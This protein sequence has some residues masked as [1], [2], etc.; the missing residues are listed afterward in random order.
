MEVRT[1]KPVLKPLPREKERA[2][3]PPSSPPL[4]QKAVTN[5]QAHTW[6]ELHTQGRKGGEKE[7]G[8]SLPFLYSIARASMQKAWSRAAPAGGARNG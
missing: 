4:V 8:G 6:P 1:R 3:T 7:G 5:T 2:T